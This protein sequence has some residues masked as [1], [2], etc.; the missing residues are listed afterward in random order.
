MVRFAGSIRQ[1]RTGTYSEHRRATLSAFEFWGH[2][3]L[4]CDLP[5]ST[6]QGRLVGTSSFARSKHSSGPP[7]IPFADMRHLVGHAI[8]GQSR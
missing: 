6:D 5:S 8:E 7:V 2:T 1:S 3:A 4:R